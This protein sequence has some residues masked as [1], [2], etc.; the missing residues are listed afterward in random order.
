MASRK[1]HESKIASVDAIVTEDVSHGG[2]VAVSKPT[3]SIMPPS[4]GSA[5]EKPLDT[6]PTTISLAPI[7]ICC[8]LAFYQ[9]VILGRD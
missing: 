6:I 4:F 7:P 9:Q 8:R 1:R 5:M 2:M 3:T